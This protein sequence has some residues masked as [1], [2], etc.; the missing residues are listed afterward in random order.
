MRWLLKLKAKNN[1]LT[2]SL[3]KKPTTIP[4][5]LYLSSS[6]VQPPQTW[7]NSAATSRA[8]SLF[9]GKWPCWTSSFTWYASRRRSLSVSP[10]TWNLKHSLWGETRG[11]WH[12]WDQQLWPCDL[13][14]CAQFTVKPDVVDGNRPVLI[15]Q[16]ND[17]RPLVFPRVQLLQSLFPLGNDITDLTD[18]KHIRVKLLLLKPSKSGG[19]TRS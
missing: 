10:F 18:R 16:S 4:L 11:G 14:P 17:P 7:A 15:R 3:Y 9:T 19:S 8:S 12:R 1:F 5:T 13:W 2:P 6:W